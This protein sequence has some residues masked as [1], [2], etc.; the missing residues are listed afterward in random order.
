MSSLNWHKYTFKIH[1]IQSQAKRTLTSEKEIFQRTILW[2]LIISA[3]LIIVP[4]VRCRVEFLIHT[5]PSLC[6]NPCHVSWR[7]ILAWLWVTPCKYSFLPFFL[8]NV[9]FQDTALMPP[10]RLIR[11]LIWETRDSEFLF[12]IKKF[13]SLKFIETSSLESAVCYLSFSDFFT[14]FIFRKAILLVRALPSISWA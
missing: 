11:R 7:R 14:S 9:K 4:P 1:V 6:G 3:I 8:M 10:P 5:L 12:K 13:F 2:A